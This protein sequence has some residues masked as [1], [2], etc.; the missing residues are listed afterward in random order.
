[1]YDMTALKRLEVTGPGAAAFLQRLVTGNVDKSVGSVT[2]CLLLDDDGGIRSDI[3][4]ARLGRDLFQVGA[5]G[6]LDLD[7]LHRRLPA[8][9]S[10]QVARHHARHL[11][12][13]ALGPAG[14][15]RRRAADRHRLLQ[16][17]R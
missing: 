1:M 10:V 8:D 17:R 4:V 7:W 2:Y 15:R 6:N 14:P 3:T 9:G 16:R 11:L 12:H 5:N 13:R